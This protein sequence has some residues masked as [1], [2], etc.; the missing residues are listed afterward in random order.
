MLPGRVQDPRASHTFQS[1]VAHPELDETKRGSRGFGFFGVFSEL[2][3]LGFNWVVFFLLFLCLYT[4]TMPTQLLPHAYAEWEGCL[5]G[6]FPRLGAYA[7]A[8]AGFFVGWPCSRWTNV[9][10]HSL[11]LVVVLNAT[12]D[13]AA[14]VLVGVAAFLGSEVVLAP[15]GSLH[16]RCERKNERMTIYCCGR[17]FGQ[18]A[19]KW[20]TCLRAASAEPTQAYAVEPR[21]IPRNH[22]SYFIFI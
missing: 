11:Q 1:T 21:Q 18:R 19:S 5:R 12:L 13:L 14:L 8:S 22:L 4:G 6:S 7:G 17:A 10:P 9:S 2:V 15:F 3:W 16:V 20:P